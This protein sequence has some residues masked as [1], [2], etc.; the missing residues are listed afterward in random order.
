M[1]RHKLLRPTLLGLLVVSCLVVGSFA[2]LRT[3]RAQIGGVPNAVVWTD[4]DQTRLPSAPAGTRIIVPTRYRTLALNTAALRTLLAR[5]PMEFTAEARGTGRV[6]ISLP[7]PDGKSARFRAEESPVMEP[8][9]ALR[10]PL[11]KTYRAQGVDDPAATARFG[12]TPAGFH[13]I[14]LSPSGT[15][16]IDPYRR[17]DVV[18]HISYFKRDYPRTSVDQFEC[19]FHKGDGGGSQ[20]L[21]AENAAAFAAALPNGA[22]LRTYRLALAADFEYSDFHSS[23]TPFPDK[24]EV[25]ANGIVPAVNRV[26]GIYE[27]EVAVHMNL[28]A[29]EDMII[30]NTT[31]DS[32]PY[33]DNDGTQMLAANQATLTSLIGPTNYDIGHVV[34]T[35]GGGVAFLG[36]VCNE[37]QKA[38]GVTGLPQPTGDPFYV[39]YVAHEMGHQFGGNHPFNGTT[40]SCAGGNRNASTAYEVGSGSTIMAYAG[41]CPAQDVQLNS[42]DYFHTISYDEIVT[43]I[44]GGGNGCAVPTATG[45]TPPTVEAGLNYNIPKQ[46]PFTL[47]AAGNDADGHPLTYNWEEFDLGPANDGR[48]DN[49]SSPIFRSYNST[50]NPSRT[51]PSLQYILNNANQPPATYRCGAGG[52][53]TCFTGEVLPTTTRAMNFRVTARDNRTTGGGADHDSMIVNVTAG[54]GPFVVTFPNGGETLDPGTN[55][56]VTWNV[57]NT[58]QAPVNAGSVDIYLST[59]GGQTFPTLLA[60]AVPND[61]SESVLI[62]AVSTITARIRI[63]A[64]NNIFFD[65]SNANF[66]IDPP[67]QPPVA[68]NDAAATGYQSPVFIPVLTNDSD[69]EGDALSISS[70]QSPTNLGGTAV[71]NNNGTPANTTDDGILYTPGQFSGLD[72]FSYTISDGSQTASALV[73]VTVAPL[74][75]PTPTGNFTANFEAGNNGFTVLTPANAPASA[76][77]TRVPDPAAHSASNS[78]FTDNAAVNGGQKSDRLISPP[79][80]LSSTSKLIFWHRFSLEPDFDGG[81]LEVSTNGGVSYSDIL[82]I[83]GTFVSGGYNHLMGNGPLA[84]RQAWNGRSTGFVNPNSAMQKVEVNLGALAGQTAIFRWHFRADDLNADEAVGWWVDDIQ[85]TNLLVAPAVCELIN[86]A[87]ATLGSVAAASSTYTSRNYSTS[88]AFDGERAGANWENGGGWNDATRDLWPDNLDVTFS[89]GAKAIRE[90]RVYTLQNDFHN[91]VV[92]DENTDASVYGIQDFEV[93]T[94]NGSDWVTVP[95]GTITGNTKAMRVITLPTPITTTGI[96]VLVQAGRVYYSRIVELEAF[97]L[98]GQ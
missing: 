9:L 39:D 33:V 85:F 19:H 45:N 79:Q 28:V 74:C 16:Y 50:T 52:S 93:Q 66:F 76:P 34:S 18:N 87:R 60:S 11:I 6:E 62:P 94:L 26:D 56:T 2:F 46:T 20:A 31:A 51:F 73:T 68:I 30:F 89:G 44:N 90:I 59:D 22:T 53:R 67:P 75:P 21:T 47:T 91:P 37:A 58:D 4:V 29:N 41:I 32:D 98:S 78:F 70:V 5:A 13:A 27:R 25:L 82:A 95:G 80:L 83:G 23:A 35:G 92:P 42:D 64:N 17:G 71:V 40:G 15:F 10:Y 69:P 77:W 1:K 12:I 24:A 54:A 57:A 55:A 84:T 72:Q 61:G 3:S 96:R 43:Y 63:S 36:V 65:I 14:V 81:V 7:M 48:T 88:G 86:Y 49:G 38:G 8:A 97:G